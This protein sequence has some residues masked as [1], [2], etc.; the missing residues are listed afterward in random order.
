M[1]NSNYFKLLICLFCVA[2]VNIVVAQKQGRMM[3]RYR[4]KHP[5]DTISLLYSL[6][7]GKFSG[8][9]RSFSMAT[10]NHE[11]LQDYYAQ[12]LGGGIAY[13]SAI[14]RKFNFK[15]SN[16]YVYEV[17]SNLTIT[18]SITGQKDRYEVTLFDVENP[19]NRNDL[20]RLEE[21]YIRYNTKQSKVTYGR[22]VVNSPLINPQD[23]RM[24]P[25]LFHGFW[26]ANTSIP[27]TTLELGWL[28]KCSPRSTIKWFDLASSI[29]VY[30]QG[31]NPNGSKSNYR[32]NVQSAGILVAGATT[33]FKKIGLKIQ[34]WDYYV[35]QIFNTAFAQIDYTPA[36]D[37]SKN[38]NKLIVG[39]QALAQNAIDDGGNTDPNKT[40]FVK[41]GKSF[42]YGGR[43]GFGN[44]LTQVTM[45]Y[46][47]I[48]D[49]GRF[50]FPREWGREPF[51]TFLTRERVEGCGN[52][53]AY[54][55]SYTQVFKG[56]NL[57]TSLG[58]GYYELPDVKN[59]ALNKYGLPSYVQANV[60]V[61]YSIKKGFYKGLDMQWILAYK[62]NEGNIYNNEK[63][64]INK[65]DMLNLNWVL[66]Y[67]F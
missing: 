57:K 10:I 50:L 60:D 52:V 39:L 43:L 2:S 22:Q 37:K 25:T 17:G 49:D 32:N 13:E 47:N 27:K 38:P 48:T 11:N 54:M 30:S 8:H 58:I 7:K 61:R 36:L 31:V 41:N 51:Y 34:A 35:D 29:G 23:S 4:D 5:K 9:L 1:P 20:D 56:Q 19:T 59:T 24:R 53:K 65:V 46:T 44:N 33:N 62:K 16:Y 55:L 67:R 28:Y 18:D 6:K 40:Y 64:R 14:F 26:W 12:A 15:V 42:A 63:Y 66:N 3:L 21:L 45:N